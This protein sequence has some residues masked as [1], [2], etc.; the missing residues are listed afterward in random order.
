MSS[1]AF[2]SI[3]LLTVMAFV[4]PSVAQARAPKKY[5]VTGKVVEVTDDLIVVLNKDEEKWE[6]GRDKSTKV[7]GKLK[8]G[9]KVTIQYTMSAAS[10]EVKDE[11]A[12]PAPEQKPAPGK[13]PVAK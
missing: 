5:Q 10:V 4:V 7:D 6:I 12:T 8:V 13:K 3:V 1:H 2:R 9:E 11:K